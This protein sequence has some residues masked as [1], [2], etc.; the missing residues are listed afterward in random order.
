MNNKNRGIVFAGLGFELMGLILTC[1]YLGQKIDEYYQSKGLGLISL[2]ILG[3]VGWFYH[4]IILL[5]KFV[6]ED[7]EPSNKDNI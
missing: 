5:R 1:L 3:I 7:N 2:V 6:A 4:L